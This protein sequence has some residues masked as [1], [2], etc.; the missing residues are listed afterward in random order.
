VRVTEHVHA[1]KI[2]FKLMISPGVLMDRLVYAYPIYGKRIG[3][4]DSGVAASHNIIFDYLRQTGRSPKEIA[5]LVLTHSHPDHIGGAYEVVAGSGC[6]VAAHIEDKPWIE[7][8]ESQFR[9]RPV[10]NFHSLV[11]NSVKVD[12][13]LQDDGDLELGEGQILKVL[14]TPGHSKGSISLFFPDDGALFTGDALPKWGG[15]PIYEDVLASLKSVRKFRKIEGIK[16]L[17]A[18]WDEP[19]F[20]DIYGLIDQGAKYIQHIH[21]L[22]S[23]E[24]AKSPSVDAV[25]LGAR[26]LQALG[27]SETALSPMVVNSI[28]AHLKVSDRK[29][30]L[31]P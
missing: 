27:F 2:P 4:I 17:F 25:E 22:V 6:Q 29:D 3:L 1:I 23:S 8:I 19:R 14:H 16:V 15:L 21:E 20:E 31:A 9:A 12:V 5:T 7:D 26:V 10:L 11:E 28:K 18:S 30:L 13:V 24:Q